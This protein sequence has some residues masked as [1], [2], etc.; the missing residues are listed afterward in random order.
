MSLW[1]STREF[2]ASNAR[3]LTWVWLPDPEADEPMRPDQTYFGVWLTHSFLARKVSWLETRYPAAHVS[4]RLNVAGETTTLTRLARPSEG[5]VGDG[6][7]TNFPVTGL[8]PY[9][10][11]TVEIEAGL[12]ALTRSSVLGA[13]VDVLGEFSGLVTPP[14]SEALQVARKVATGVQTLLDAGGG[15]IALGLHQAY[16]PPGGGADQLA[17]G[18]LAVIG[19]AHGELAREKLLVDENRLHLRDGDGSAPLEGYDYLL[20]EIESQTERPDWRFPRF[21]RLIHAAITAHFAGEKASFERHRNDVLA[22]V[23]NSPDLT[24]PDRRRIAQAVKDELEMATDV[25]NGMDAPPLLSFEAIVR[26]HV[27]PLADPRAQRDVSLLD[28]IAD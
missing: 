25:S 2:F 12:T 5:M 14:V 13:A 9:R 18:H 26:K 4:V 28:L 1:E 22:E 8:I 15:E 23:L 27:V 17:P 10:G 19:A 16:S 7:W 11:G 24:L 3:Q 21:E 20:L 6:V